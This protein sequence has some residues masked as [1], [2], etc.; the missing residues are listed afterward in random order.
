MKIAFIIFDGITWLDLIGVYDAIS[1]L[2]IYEY[3]PDLS[4]DFCALTPTAKD[5]LGLEMTVTKI[6]NDLGGY[7][8]IIVPGGRGT[9]KLVHDNDF[10]AWL[11]TAEAVKYKI[12][13]CTGSLLLGAAN[14]LRGKKATTN[15]GEYETLSRYCKEVVKDRIVIDGDTI[16]AG[17]VASSLDLGIFLCQKW[18]G[19]EAAKVIASKMDYQSVLLAESV[20]G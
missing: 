2:K 9:R 5:D 6:K 8:A 3:I 1:R 11:K 10:I 12:S 18:A 15:F 16:T 19:D 20:K 4:W 14:F 13:I 7:D 17:A